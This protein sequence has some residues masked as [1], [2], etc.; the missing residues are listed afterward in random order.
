[1][2]ALDYCLANS[3]KESLGGAEEPNDGI[4]MEVGHARQ[5]QRSIDMRAIMSR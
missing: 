3:S 2:R 1:M 5:Q 4:L